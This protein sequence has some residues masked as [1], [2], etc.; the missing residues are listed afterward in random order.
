MTIPKS[1]FEKTYKGY[2]EQIR[3]MPFDSI[4]D[5]LGAKIEGNRLK[6]PL[7]INEYEVSVEGIADPSGKKPTHDICVI[8]SK[9]I[10][11]CPVTPPKGKDWVSFR[12]FKDS[13]PLLNYF[14][15]EVERALGSYFS[16]KLKVLKEVSDKLGG[17]SP[18]LEVRYDLAVQF[19]ALPMIPVLMLYNDAD[20]E[21]SAKCSVL[22]ESRAEKYLDA[23]CIAMLGWQL[24]SHLRKA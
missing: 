15:N 12:N 10:L 23:E 5:N 16:G 7:F 22:F 19:D 3:K 11:L 1:V 17:Y 20:E 6:I 13:A 9:Y 24:F 21:F 4:A 8:L 2:L 14:T 18:D